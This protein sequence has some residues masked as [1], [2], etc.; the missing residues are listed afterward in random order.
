MTS[1]GV[2]LLDAAG[3][4]TANTTRARR[5]GSSYPIT[6]V[7]L[8]P[9]S[10][11]IGGP[12]SR[13][14][15][16]LLSRRRAPNSDRRGHSRHPGRCRDAT[17]PYRSTFLTLLDIP[18]RH[19]VRTRTFSSF[20]ERRTATLPVELAPSTPPL[21]YKPPR[22]PSFSCA[23][24]S[25]L[26]PYPSSLSAVLYHIGLWNATARIM[27]DTTRRRLDTTS[28]PL[29]SPRRAAHEPGRPLRLSWEP[30]TCNR[31]SRSCRREAACPSTGR[32]VDCSRVLAKVASDRTV[33]LVASRSST[34]ERG[35]MSCI[36]RSSRLGSL[37]AQCES[38]VSFNNCER[39]PCF[40]FNDVALVSR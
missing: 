26:A 32:A 14:S 6:L 11:S 33:V 16:A 9:A 1:R 8:P 29:S 7:R 39:A 5:F 4:C 25:L 20:V 34:P 30:A 37:V 19:P 2:L 17:R 12:A 3:W 31:R 24:S 27:K 23:P 22:P 10:S 15:Y 40:S 21:A 35:C 13:S 36:P 18:T 38:L 28:L